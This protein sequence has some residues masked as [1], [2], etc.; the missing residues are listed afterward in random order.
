MSTKLH[1][2]CRLAAGTDVFAFI[3]KLRAVLDPIR[4]ELDAARLADNAVGLVDNADLM[5]EPRPETPHVQAVLNWFDEQEKV[6]PKSRYYD[7]HRF[8]LAIGYD[9]YT[10][11]HL[12]LPFV[13]AE[14]LQLAFVG[15]P[16]VEP[17]F[18]RGSF[19]KPDYFSQEEWDG[20]HAAWTRVLGYKT[21]KE[22]MLMMSLR[23]GPDAGSA[24][25]EVFSADGAIRLKDIA[26]TKEKRAWRLSINIYTRWLA[27]QSEDVN[28][29]T[30]KLIRQA[31]AADRTPLTDLITPALPEVTEELLST[32]VGEHGWDNIR[33]ALPA[34]CQEIHDAQQAGRKA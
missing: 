12:L 4:D 10:D 33:E 2:G 1:H 13:D 14:E 30:I 11:R 19:D 25:G 6:D 17:Y 20:R 26:P 28:P 21:P 31:G 18:Y 32:G 34:A 23:N 15:M 22:A 8:E 16:E 9:A 3:A 24:F 5:N 29:D 27:E 7:P